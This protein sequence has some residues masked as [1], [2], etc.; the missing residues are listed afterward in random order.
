MRYYVYAL[1]GN[2]LKTFYAPIEPGSLAG[3]VKYLRDHGWRCFWRKT[4]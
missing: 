1:K 2:R 3:Q 4:K